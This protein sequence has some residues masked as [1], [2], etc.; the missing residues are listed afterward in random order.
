MNA[1]ERKP[2]KEILESLADA[3]KVFIAACTG[4]PVGCDVGGEAWIA[5]ITRPIDGPPGSTW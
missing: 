3:K 1:S 4:C 2:E 5:D